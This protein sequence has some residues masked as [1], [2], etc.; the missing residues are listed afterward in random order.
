MYVVPSFSSSE[1]ATP[2]ALLP[3]VWSPGFP[4]DQGSFGSLCASSSPVTPD[5][6]VA[7][8]EKTLILCLPCL[9][10]LGVLGSSGT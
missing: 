7:L 1:P 9:G 4:D 2:S 5:S 8:V 3:S 10:P 6:V